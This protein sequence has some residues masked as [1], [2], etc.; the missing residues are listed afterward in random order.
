MA[1]HRHAQALRALPLLALVACASRPTPDNAAV[2]KA[3][4]GQAGDVPVVAEGQA[5]PNSPRAFLLQ[6]TGECDLLLQ[7]DASA[8]QGKLPSMGDVVIVSGTYG[9]TASGGLVKAR[10]ITPAPS[11]P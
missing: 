11:K 7:V 6:L 8:V 4:G 3:Y 5:N 1:V 9:F 10:E 2:C